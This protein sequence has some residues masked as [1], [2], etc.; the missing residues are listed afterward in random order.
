MPVSPFARWASIEGE[1]PS[2][3][4]PPGGSPVQ[5]EGI[6]VLGGTTS[7]GSTVLCQR[8]KPVNRAQHCVNIMPRGAMKC[9]RPCRSV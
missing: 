8:T 6:C 1:A 3:A 4:A 2:P 9:D 5:V 7:N